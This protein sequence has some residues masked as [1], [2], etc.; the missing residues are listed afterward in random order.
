MT[1]EQRKAHPSALKQI[2][3]LALRPSRDLGQLARGTLKEFPTLIRY[4]LRGVGAQ[5][6]KGWDLVSYLAF[7]AAY[8]GQLAELGYEDTYSR[9]E[10]IQEFLFGGA[11]VKNSRSL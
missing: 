10:E 1:E 11:V 2:P 4:L 9:K 5:D 6:D 3:I 7:E 8:T